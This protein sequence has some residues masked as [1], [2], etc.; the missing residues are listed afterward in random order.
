MVKKCFYLTNLISLRSRL[1]LD[2]ELHLKKNWR[3]TP[4][5]DQIAFGR[6]MLGMTWSNR[7]ISVS[8]YWP[9]TAR[10]I[11]F[12]RLQPMRWEVV[13]KLGPTIFGCKCCIVIRRTSPIF[14]LLF[15]RRLISQHLYVLRK[16]LSNYIYVGSQL[17]LICNPRNIYW[18]F[19]Y[20]FI[21]AMPP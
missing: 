20:L 1:G 9:I 15:L 19:N 16:Q 21:W 13:G 12:S 5:L 18:N 6:V 4:K 10:A 11:K 14:Q 17:C 8:S 7:C 2:R 3:Q